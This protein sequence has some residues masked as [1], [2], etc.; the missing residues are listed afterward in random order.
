MGGGGGGGGGGGCFAT[1][2]PSF[3][4]AWIGNTALFAQSKRRPKKMKYLPVYQDLPYKHTSEQAKLTW[5]N[6][7][8]STLYYVLHISE[9]PSTKP[10]ARITY[11]T[12][13]RVDFTRKGGVRSFFQRLF[14]LYSGTTARVLLKAQAEHQHFRKALD[15]I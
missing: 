10:T 11:D 4:S 7:G 13:K 5:A 14:S 1:A 15:Q 9:L 3:R 8:L 12:V 6:G 2:L